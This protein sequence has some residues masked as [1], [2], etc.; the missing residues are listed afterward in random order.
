M[1]S[2]CEVF[3]GTLIII[4]YAIIVAFLLFLLFLLMEHNYLF[5]RKRFASSFPS[6]SSRP[7]PI[8]ISDMERQVTQFENEMK[9]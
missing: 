8:C 6:L 4:G 3:M 2:T 5:L 7:P 1:Y 9:Y